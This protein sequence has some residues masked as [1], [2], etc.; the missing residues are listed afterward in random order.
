MSNPLTRFIKGPALK[1]DWTSGDSAPLKYPMEILGGS[2]AY[3]DGSGSL[4]V[5]GGTY[6][7]HGW[8]TTYSSQVMGPDL[9][10]LPNRL[11]ITFF[12]FTENK[13]YRGD[14]PLPYE[15]IL[16]RF[17]EG[18][19]NLDGD[20]ITYDEILVGVAP[21]GAVAVWLRGV[22]FTTEVFFGKA[23]AADDI[24]WS[25][26]TSATHITREQ[27]VQKMIK[28]SLK[29]PE[30]YAALQKNGVPVGLWERYRTRYAWKPVFPGI[31]LTPKRNG[32]IDSIKS[33]NGEEE[34]VDPAVAQATRVVPRELYFSGAP[35]GT[36]VG[37]R[38]KSVK[39]FFHEPEILAA[40]EKLGAG[41]RPLQLEVRLEVIDNQNH[42]SVWLKND[43]ETLEL[44][45]TTIKSYNTDA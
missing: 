27:Y 33:F 35:V 14:F 38:N 2:L 26:L 44:K 42:F 22:S 25:A 7:D 29:T 8:G 13:F 1:F 36:P 18:Y 23:E 6:I 11:R 12:S 4:P 40:F 30:A 28:A 17:Q 21:G 5:R 34:I 20:R 16:K 31:R 10:P 45:R 3:H 41:G 9:K 24:P 43:K 37:T 19:D 39:L 15:M 32:R